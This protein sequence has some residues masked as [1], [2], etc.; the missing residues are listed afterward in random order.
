MVASLSSRLV[1]CS[2]KYKILKVVFC[3]EKGL[4]IQKTN[5]GQELPPRLPCTE[6]FG[7]VTLDA[8]ASIQQGSFFPPR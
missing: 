8:T 3:K 2:F 4:A 7:S 6:A 1:S 5:T